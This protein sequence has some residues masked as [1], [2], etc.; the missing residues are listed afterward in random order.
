MARF[1]HRWAGISEDD[2]A[3]WDISEV[4]YAYRDNEMILEWAAKA[5]P[6][7]ALT[8]K[9]LRVEGKPGARLECIADE[10]E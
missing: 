2:A 3:P 10:P 6:G 8:G 9:A 4:R 1:R 7:D 5:K